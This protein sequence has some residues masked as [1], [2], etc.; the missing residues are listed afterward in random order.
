MIKAPLRQLA[1]S[2]CHFQ[3]EGDARLAISLLIHFNDL[4]YQSLTALAFHQSHS[5]AADFI[6]LS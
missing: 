3:I 6:G 5:A 1:I 4:S 2:A